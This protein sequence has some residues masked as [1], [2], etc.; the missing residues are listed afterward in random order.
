M[1]I[2]NI[3]FT[4]INYIIPGVYI[5]CFSIILFIFL[6]RHFFSNIEGLSRRKRKN[7]SSKKS[8][9][10]KNKGKI[11]RCPNIIFEIV[12]FIWAFLKG[13]SSPEYGFKFLYGKS[14]GTS[15]IRTPNPPTAAKLNNLRIWD[16]LFLIKSKCP[17]ERWLSNIRFYRYSRRYAK[18]KKKNM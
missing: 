16:K 4:N 14:V 2:G 12:Y 1:N 13:E 5:L 8:S 11:K 9:S 6:K 3:K 17:A 7:R 18:Y 15:P 10:S